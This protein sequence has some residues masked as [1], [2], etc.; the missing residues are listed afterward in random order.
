[1]SCLFTVARS[2][3]WRAAGLCFGAAA[4]SYSGSRGDTTSSRA[5]LVRREVRGVSVDLARKSFANGLFYEANG[6]Q[7]ERRLSYPGKR[8]DV[9]SV[10]YNHPLGG[11]TTETSTVCV[12]EPSRFVVDVI[13]RSPNVPLGDRFLTLVTV[14]VF[15]EGDGIDLIT[16]SRVVW[17]GDVGFQLLRSRIETAAEKGASRAYDNL[18]SALISHVDPS[19]ADLDNFDNQE[20]TPPKSTRP[21]LSLSRIAWFV[22]V[23]GFFVCAAPFSSPRI[24]P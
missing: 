19:N 16:N 2:V 9:L 6:Y 11:R 1:M 20:P 17:C 4:A 15:G 18:A 23:T 24:V 7:V 8:G 13:A 10:E 22:A 14:E 12:N 5:E 21:Q 3:E